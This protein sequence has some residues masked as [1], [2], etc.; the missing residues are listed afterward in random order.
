MCQVLFY[1]RISQFPNFADIY[2]DW[3]NNISIL[4]LSY[5]KISHFNF[6]SIEQLLSLQY[7][8]LRYNAIGYYYI[9]VTSAT[10][11]TPGCLL[12]GHN[13]QGDNFEYQNY[14]ERLQIPFIDFSFNNISTLSRNFYKGFNFSQI[15]LSGNK[16]RKIDLNYFY[17]NQ[18]LQELD[19]SNNFIVNITNEDA[20]PLSSLKNVNLSHNNL[21]N[22]FPN[23]ISQLASLEE[24]DLSFNRLID[25]ESFMSVSN[26]SL[27]IYGEGNP[28]KC[29]CNSSVLYQKLSGKHT[30][31]CRDGGDECL[32]CAT[33]SNL[34]GVLIQN[35]FCL[36]PKSTKPT[37]TQS[38][39][40]QPTSTGISNLTTI[41]LIVFGILAIIL[42]SIGIDWKIRQRS[43]KKGLIT[44]FK[45][46]HS[47]QETQ[48]AN[49]KAVTTSDSTVQHPL[50]ADQRSD[51]ATGNGNMY[52]NLNNLQQKDK[53]SAFDDKNDYVDVDV[54]A[55]QEQISSGGRN[56][57]TYQNHS[58][59]VDSPLPTAEN[60]YDVTP[61]CN[62]SYG[63]NGE[64]FYVQPVN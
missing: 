64:S 57:N 26:L 53:L 14:S 58:S 8:D 30:F 15:S 18:E 22:I 27:R 45:Q 7:I 52:Q 39:N 43:N 23:I 59:H 35:T 61:D 34:T 16:L 42:L 9:N 41:L 51:D 49:N 36:E 24:L 11:Q 6:N 13:L 47:N 33:P 4:D 38:S 28:W 19:V 63:E 10:L 12:L 56:E 25:F 40:T 1:F 50:K 48:L 29:N 37:T 44:K 5:N 21:T 46:E 17:I 3:S 62:L 54:I 60:L 55:H 2:P 31:A 20:I 32:Y